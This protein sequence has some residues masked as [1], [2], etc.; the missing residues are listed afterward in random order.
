MSNV[1]PNV[2]IPVDL[3]NPGQ[4]FACCGLL[5]L[6]SR[7]WPGTE[8]WFAE[9]AF[10]LSTREEDGSVSALCKAVIG[11]AFSV[12]LPVE[13][14]N[15]LETLNR[16]KSEL[17][18]VS[19]ALPKT[20]EARRKALNSRR[21]ASGFRLGPPFDLQVDWWL[22]EGCDADHLKTWAGQQAIAGIAKAI[23]FSLFVAAEGDIFQVEKTVSRVDDEPGKPVAPLS[24]D[25]GRVGTAQD[26]GYSPDK[27]GQPLT[28][29]VWTE[30]LTLIALQRFGLTPDRNDF[31][32]YHIWCEPLEVSVA[33]VAARGAFQNMIAATGTF[34]LAAR[35]SGNRYKAFQQATLTEWR[36]T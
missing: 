2:T 31:F 20:D 12:L 28:C 9:N 7:R 35:D 32:T 6:A 3:T 14:L 18:K 27:V 22:I 15:L 21:I 16:R 19:K 13:E 26:I 10:L 17:K 1:T 5:E 34:R 30:F 8:G 4:F 24:F 36:S 11:C 33:A 25:A 23:K 29:C